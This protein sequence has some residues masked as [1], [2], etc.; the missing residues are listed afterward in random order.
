M[1]GGNPVYDAPADFDFG[2]TLLKAKLRVHSGLYYDETAELCHWHVPEAHFLESWSDARAYRRHGGHRS[3]A[4]RAAV[5]GPVGARN[6]VGAGGRVREIGARSRSGLLE[7]AAPG[8][9][10]SIRSVLGDVVA[11][12]RDGWN[13]VAGDFGFAA[14]WIS[15]NSRS[16]SARDPNTLEIVYRPDPTIGDGRFA[17]NGWLQE[18][19]KTITRLTWDNAALVSTNTAERLDLRHGEYMKLKLAGR[20]VYAGIFADPGPPGQFDHAASRLRTPA[21]G[22]RGQRAGLQCYFCARRTRRGWRLGCSSKDSAKKYYFAVHAVPLHDEEDGHPAD[23]ESVNAFRRDLVQ[24]ATLEEFRKDPN[25]AQDPNE[26]SSKELSLFPDSSP[27]A[28]RGA[29]RSI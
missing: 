23:T 7:G 26:E 20:E 25:F 10:Q 5:P 21:R 2:P 29:C 9:R 14:R 4:D 11:R 8:K 1:L 15:A 24:V 28:T 16:N 18:L 12:R 27:T 17:N 22:K 19:P 6:C 3:A 13:G